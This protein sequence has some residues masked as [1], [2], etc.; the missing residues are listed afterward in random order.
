M[1]HSEDMQFA[2]SYFYFLMSA[3][4]QLN[5][6]EVF[7]D[8]DTDHSGVLSD[9]EIRTLATRIHELPLSLQVSRR[10]EKPSPS[11][12]QE[13]LRHIRMCLC[14]LLQDLTGLEQMLINC[15][16]TLPTNLTQ[17]HLV[18]PTQETYYDP[19][20]VSCAE[21]QGN[22]IHKTSLVLNYLSGILCL[23]VLSLLLQK[24]W[25]S[26]VSP[27]QSESTKPSETRTSTSAS[28]CVFET[29][30]FS[31]FVSAG[32]NV[33]PGGQVRDHGR[34]GNSFQ[35]GANQ[36]VARGRTVGRHQEESEVRTTER[37]GAVFVTEQKS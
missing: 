19:S 25:S 18:S 31:L 14:L 17:L 6:S 29:H 1:R 9:R 36:R 34:G 7:D 30:T 37:N 35:D 8:I 22:K 21:Q 28:D 16:R 20:M 26:T 5:V 13:H 2:F 27:S 11:Q 24:A 23:S 32:A 3:Q 12:R 4:Q 33:S 15:S 10:S